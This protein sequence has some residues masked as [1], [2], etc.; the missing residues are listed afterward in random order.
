MKQSRKLNTKGTN[1]NGNKVGLSF[2]SGL[3][4]FYKSTID[5]INIDCKN[6]AVMFTVFANSVK[7]EIEDKQSDNYHLGGKAGYRTFANK[8]LSLIISKRMNLQTNGI[9]YFD[10]S[11]E[12]RHFILKL[13]N[14]INQ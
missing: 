6:Q 13:N 4:T 9:H 1:R 7:M 12:G 5:L 10:I 2:P 8:E 14:K 11:K 3:F